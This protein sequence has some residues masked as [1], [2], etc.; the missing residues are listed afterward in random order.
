L[1]LA[2]TQEMVQNGTEEIEKQL[3]ITS[4]LHRPIGF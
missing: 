1:Q 2:E 4:A 3:R